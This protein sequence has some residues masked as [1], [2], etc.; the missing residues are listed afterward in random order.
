[1]RTWKF[2]A[3]I[4]AA[5]LVAGSVVANAGGEAPDRSDSAGPVTEAPAAHPSVVRAVGWRWTAVLS[6]ESARRYRVTIGG[7]RLDGHK[8]TGFF[9]QQLRTVPRTQASFVPLPKQSD[10][11]QIGPGHPTRSFAFRLEGGRPLTQVDR[12]VF[13][14]NAG[15]HPFPVV[16]FRFAEALAGDRQ[17]AQ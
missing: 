17:P 6:K 15:A 2:L 1:V 13:A 9:R 4:A 7:S 16:R 3:L 10:L 11:G 12:F 14:A 8:R 5:L